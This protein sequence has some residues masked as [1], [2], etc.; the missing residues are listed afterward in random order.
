MVLGRA[1]DAS[2]LE[3]RLTQLRQAREGVR[4]LERGIR[5]RQAFFAL[6]GHEFRTPLATL[7]LQLEVAL[8]GLAKRDPDSHEATRLQRA[9]LQTRCLTELTDRLLDVTQLT[10]RGVELDRRPADLAVIVREQVAHQR[11]TAESARCTVELDLQAADG[12]WDRASIEQ[13]IENLLS[14]AFKFGAGKPVRVEVRQ[15]RQMAVLTVCDHGIGIPIADQD[16]IFGP[17][18]RAVSERHY[19]GFGVGLWIVRQ[20]VEAHGG[21]VRVESAPTRGA[22]FRVSLP[23]DPKSAGAAEGTRST[24]ER[25]SSSTRRVL[26]DELP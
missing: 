20:I 13:V 22:T 25:S 12:E 6:A 21:T 18:E 19:K 15:E 24:T 3:W 17:F 11:A 4:T 1:T 5:A 2:R 8:A 9:L 14:N 7:Q 16:R 26:R 10:A 23:S